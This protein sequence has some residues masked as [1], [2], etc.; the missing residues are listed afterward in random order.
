MKELK[1]FI[2][3]QINDYREE[4]QEIRDRINEC[5]E[6]LEYQEDILEDIEDMNLIEGI[7]E[8]LHVALGKINEMEVSK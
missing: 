3:D 5:R 4:F 6:D 1:E 8:G 7:I 2:L